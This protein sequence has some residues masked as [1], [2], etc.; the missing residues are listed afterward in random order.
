MTAIWGAAFKNRNYDPRHAGFNIFRTENHLY[1]IVLVT[2][3]R[4]DVSLPRSLLLF[5]QP[6]RYVFSLFSDQLHVTPIF[7][8]GIASCEK[9]LQNQIKTLSYQEAAG[10]R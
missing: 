3:V 10:L 1:H 5:N 9:N 7:E 2:F 8:H 6:S 4:A